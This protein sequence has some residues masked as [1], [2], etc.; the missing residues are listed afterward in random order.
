M[1]SK[2]RCIAVNIGFALSAFFFGFACSGRFPSLLVA[3]LMAIMVTLPV[4]R[5]ALCGTP[6][7]SAK[8]IVMILIFAVLGAIVGRGYYWLMHQ[9]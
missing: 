4:V 7:Q 3:L 1:T 6:I 5:Q 8:N 2:H 9:S